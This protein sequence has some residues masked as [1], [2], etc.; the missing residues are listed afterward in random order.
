M[1]AHRRVI[2]AEGNMSAPKIRNPEGCRPRTSRISESWHDA[3]VSAAGMGH[4]RRVDTIANGSALLQKAAVF[5]RC[6]A[7]ALRA[8]SRHH[9]D[10]TIFCLSGRVGTEEPPSIAVTA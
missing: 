4:L 9:C 2:G 5:L 7:L 10:A 3:L 6:G 1:G 8:N